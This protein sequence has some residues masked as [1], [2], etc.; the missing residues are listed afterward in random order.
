M[1]SPD[2]AIVAKIG[3][4]I[5]PKTSDHA[6]GLSSGSFKVLVLPS[7]IQGKKRD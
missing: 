5:Q 4:C 1:A 3:K 6:E 7:G 2:A